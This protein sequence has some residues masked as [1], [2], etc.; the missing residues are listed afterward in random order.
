MQNTSRLLTGLGLVLTLS[1]TVFAANHREAPLTALDHKV[2]ITDVYAFV[3][4]DNPEKVTLIMNVDPLLEP[5]NGPTRFPFD[6]EVLYSIKI[7]NN[8]DAVEDYSFDFRFTT[9][10]RQPGVF[11]GLFGAGNGLVAPDNSP[12]PVLP[13]SPVFPSAITALDGPGSEGLNLSQ[14]YN[15]TMIK[16]KKGRAKKRDIKSLSKG[17]KLF[18]VPSNTGPRTMPNYAD[19][20]DQGIYDLGDGVKVFAGTVD[21][22]FYIDLGAVFDSFN[23]RTAAFDTGV[24]GVLSDDQDTDDQ[25]NFAPDDIAGFNVNSIAIEIPIKLITHDGYRHD[26]TEPEATIGV[27]ATTSRPREKKFARRP[28]R[29]DRVSK[30][31]VQRQR[32]ANPLINEL[33]IGIGSKDLF[34]KSKP[35]DDAQFAGFVLDPV[36]ARV[37]NALYDTI[38]PGVLPVPDAPRNDLLPL[39]QYMPPIAA[40]GTPKGPIADL[41]RLN[42]GIPATAISNRSRLGFL[43]LLDDD[44]ANDDP[45]GFPNGRRVS[46]DVVDITTRVVIGILAGSGSNGFPHNRVGDGVNQNDVPYRE[47]FPYVGLAHSGVESR[48]IDTGELGCT[49]NCP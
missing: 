14:Q 13:G 32:M 24:P 35:K 39:V 4:Y 21:D 11:V 40:P 47:T 30:K 37:L 44:A 25:Q 23:L 7:D 34:S 36:L 45:A 18:A 26:A 12:M 38:S 46:D 31:L 9:N 15:V 1:S 29:Q 8:H 43:T 19:L 3:S 20:T 10:F 6:P 48:H 17:L 42:T 22:P 49:G 5:S 28:D 41:L 33:L 16:Y 2:D 27:W